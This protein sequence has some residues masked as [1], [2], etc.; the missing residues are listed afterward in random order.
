[1]NGAGTGVE[2]GWR[3]MLAASLAAAAPPLAAQTLAGQT[4]PAQTAAGT[5]I[6][7]VAVLRSDGAAAIG[8]NPVT[9]VVA[10]RLDCTLAR[11]PPPAAGE[12]SA[13]GILLT[14]TGNGREA[15]AVAAVGSD[16]APYRLAVDADGDGRF[17]AAR[18][19]WL[20]D[21]ITPDLAPGATVR[22]L[23]PVGE[24]TTPALTVTARATTG[25][26][27]P[28]AVFAGL[29]DGGGDAVVGPGGGGARLA[30]AAAFAGPPTLT[31]TQ[32]VVTG[33]ADCEAARRGAVV[34]YTLVVR[35]GAAATAATL[36]DPVPVGTAYLPASLTLD[37]VAVADA[38][39]LVDGRVVVALGPVAAGAVHRLAFTVVVQ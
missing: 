12:G 13:S 33:A 37:D 10:E 38:G 34:R 29:G 22:L 16:G 2:V 24:A 8:S 7:N 31:Q 21:G 35:F 9:L 28:G 18:D 20:D 1:M 11:T 32:A 26:G 23:A 19:R 36:I 39:H 4:V 25:S 14:N 3:A 6:A 5:R 27:S 30:I 17:D 15:F